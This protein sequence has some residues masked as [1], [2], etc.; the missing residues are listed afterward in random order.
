[1][2]NPGARWWDADEDSVA[3]KV[4]DY[5]SEVESAQSGLFDR[6]VK[7]AALYDPYDDSSNMGYWPRGSAP[8]GGPDGIVSENLIASNVDTVA[9]EISATNV[10]ARFMTDDADW[11]TQRRARHMEFYAEALCKTMDIDSRH[12]D[13]FKIGALKGTG[14][15]KVWVDWAE[16]RP[17]A[18]VLPPDDI[19][20][21]EQ[22]VRA[23][24]PLQ[25]HERAF[26]GREV[27]RAAYPEKSLEIDRAQNDSGS[28]WTT[29]ANYRPI[30]RD[31]LVVIE[32]YRLPVG[33]RGSE[34][35]VKGRH[36]VC[37]DGTPIVDEEWLEDFFPYSVF[38]WS[39][40]PRKWYGIGLAERI[41]GHQRRKNKLSWQI[42]RQLDQHAV[43]T[44]YVGAADANLAVKSTNRI[45]TIAVVKGNP[46]VTVI[47]QAVSA[48]TY[49]RDE[50]ITDRAYE[51]TGL[52]RMAATSRKPPGLD[53]GVAL[54]EYRDQRSTRF[55]LPE[56]GFE[57][58]K[59]DIVWLLMWACKQLGDDAP[60]MTRKTRYGKKKLR[61]SD[62]DLGEV[63]LQLAAASDLA[64]TPAGRTQ[65]ALEWAQA[66]VISQDEARRLMRHPDTE[67]AM[68]LYTAALENLEAT[69]EDILD[70]EEGIVPEPYQ[71]LKMG[72]WRF[73]QG[74][75]K[76][77]QDG[78]PEEILDNIQLWI[79]QAAWMLDM[80][81]QPM[82][83]QQGAM[84]MEGV[85][86]P[87]ELLPG[88]LPQGPPQGPAPQS[89]LAP[90]AMNLIAQ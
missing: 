88:G 59:L 86:G 70:G 57:Q 8:W 32:S 7:L 51:E 80:A 30:D 45:G 14:L 37:I 58:A 81:E 18:E 15:V 28:R 40:R 3:Q 44:T 74:Y 53:S 76:A 60:V 9:A 13:Q 79:V 64:R 71:N 65:L 39:R 2:F 47:P 34:H 84:P 19:I 17:R 50:Q 31:E 75:L 63:R 22:E 24:E 6:F 4:F 1:M 35:F 72:I 29:W 21:D 69:L 62:V 54:R 38:R 16:K 52:S 55:A 23:G 61:W 36:T 25:M 20:V 26:V 43:P 77:Q 41:S 27:L 33:E 5:V 48:E 90:E 12:R 68:S 73:Q 67:R 46:P 42:D 66:G 82:A 78:A 56:K 85:A 87:P 89:A 10:R 83:P 11:S 49:R